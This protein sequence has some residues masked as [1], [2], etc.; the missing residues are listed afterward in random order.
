M[1]ENITRQPK[2]LPTGGRFAAAAHSESE[3]SLAAAPRRPELEGWPT[4]LPEPEVSIHLGD[5]GA[6][7]TSVSIDGE[8]AIDVWNPGEDVHSVETSNFEMGWSE[9]DQE[10]AESWTKGRHEEIARELRAEIHAT[11]E[12]SRAR[13]LAKA[14]GTRA[15]TTTAELSAFHDRSLEAARQADEDLELSGVA[16]SARAVLEQHPTAATAYL[17]VGSWDNGEF[18]SGAVIHDAEGNRVYEY[19]ETDGA[20]DEEERDNYVV[21]TLKSLSATPE[22]SHWASAFSTGNYGDELFTI[23]LRK[24]AAWTPGDDV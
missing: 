18:I 21:D 3:V 11:F 22:Q 2:G 9:E 8:T 5:D 15:E 1:T 17:Q 4:H 6:I 13:V 10:Q 20:T 23:D 12:R 14:T 7:T 19:I 24:A 16:L